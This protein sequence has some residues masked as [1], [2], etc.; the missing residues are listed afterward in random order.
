MSELNQKREREVI[1]TPVDAFLDAM[2]PLRDL[3]PEDQW[4]VNEREGKNVFLFHHISA[5]ERKQLGNGKCLT[6]VILERDRL[7]F[8]REEEDDPTQEFETQ[9][10]FSLNTQL[11]KV[12]QDGHDE[13][14]LNDEAQ[15]HTFLGLIFMHQVNDVLEEKPNL[16]LNANALRD[17]IRFL[18][19]YI[20]APADWMKISDLYKTM[21]RK[22]IAAELRNFYRQ[23]LANLKILELKPLTPVLEMRLRENPSVWAE[24]LK[25]RSLTK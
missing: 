22:L 2:R 23:R 25:T 18:R 4:H 16:G 24:L 14:D 20:K 12:N 7:I 6:G 3:I 15:M 8:L 9:K 17:Y 19:Q 5:W 10:A 13:I 21:E 11:E 1:Y